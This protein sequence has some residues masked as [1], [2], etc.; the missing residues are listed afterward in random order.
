MPNY[1]RILNVIR[2]LVVK[3]ADFNDYPNLNLPVRI[4]NQPRAWKGIGRAW[5]GGHSITART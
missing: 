3:A 4:D 1:S 2:I 5:V